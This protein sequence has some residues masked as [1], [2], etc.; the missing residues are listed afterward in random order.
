MTKIRTTIFEI[1]KIAG[2]SASTVSRALNNSS[3]VPEITRQRIQQIAADNHFQ[4]HA[5]ARNLRLQRTRTIAMIIPFGKGSDRRISDPFYVEMIGVIANELADHDYDLLVSRST[6]EDESW[7]QRYVLSKRVDGLIII[8]RKVNDK[9]IAHLEKMETNFV[10]WGPTLPNQNYVSVGS[11][12]IT[13]VRAAVQHLYDQGRRR[14]GFIGGDEDETEVTLRL[15]GYLQGL[16]DCGIIYDKNLVTY[17]HFTSESGFNAMQRLLYQSPDIDGVFACSD[18]IAIAAMETL[19]NEGRRVPNDIAVVG[20][21]DMPIA[22]VCFPPLTTIR[23]LIQ[24]GGMLLVNKLLD[25]IEGIEVKSVVLPAELIVR[26][27]STV[28]DPYSQNNSSKFS[29]SQEVQPDNI[30]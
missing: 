25:L 8:G 6:S 12:H 13:G 15:E 29:H 22:G 28:M 30:T 2:V 23:Q 20:Y 10:V 1:A 9:A 16:K 14:I 21:D 19:R 17:T 24:E 4:F 7:Y 27:S 5:G 3:L 18:L 26:A 11:D